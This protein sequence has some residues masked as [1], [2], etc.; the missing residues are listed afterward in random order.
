MTSAALRTTVLATSA[1]LAAGCATLPAAP[2]MQAVPGRRQTPERFAADDGQCRAAATAQLGG[3]TPSDAANQSA[4]ASTAAGAAIG[5]VSGALID[6]SSGAAAGAGM[7]LLFGA[8]AGAGASQGAYAATQQQFDTLYYSCMYARGHKVPV[9]AHDAARYR[10]LY[11]SR[12]APMARS[13]TPPPM[14]DA[15]P[16][17]SRPPSAPPPR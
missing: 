2:T 14:A 3:T 7:G 12:S 13:E 9:P 5:A 11:E 4:A 8:L 17:D 6:G 16:L 10:A 1:L 15:P